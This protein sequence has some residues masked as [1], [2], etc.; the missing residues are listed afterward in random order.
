MLVDVMAAVNPVTR[1]GGVETANALSQPF[2]EYDTNCPLSISCLLLL[3]CTTLEMSRI[4]ATVCISPNM[5][6][7]VTTVY[8]YH[9]TAHRTVIQEHKG[10]R[11]LW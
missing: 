1:S 7:C 6:D 5:A 2:G 3:C 4:H 8:P 9:T 11:P 10:N